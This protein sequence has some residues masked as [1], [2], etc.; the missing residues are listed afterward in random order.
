MDPGGLIKE[1]ESS[2]NSK[3]VTRKYEGAQFNIY[4][5]TIKG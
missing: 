4:H 3:S 2:K 5:Y 1:E